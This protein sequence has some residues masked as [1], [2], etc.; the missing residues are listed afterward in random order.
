[1]A[2]YEHTIRFLT[3][4]EAADITYKQVD[5]AM[6]HFSGV[7]Q[8]TYDSEEITAWQAHHEWELEFKEVAKYYPGEKLDEIE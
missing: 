1:M 4:D 8:F 5:K 3:D 2:L 6:G 7:V